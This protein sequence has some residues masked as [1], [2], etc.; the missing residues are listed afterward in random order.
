MRSHLRPLLIV[1]FLAEPQSLVRA[2]AMST[3]S[4]RGE[5]FEPGFTPSCNLMSATGNAVDT[6]V[7]EIS[8][9]CCE[10]TDSD[11]DDSCTRWC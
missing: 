11:D 4:C 3:I 2:V 7:I 5:G 6:V 8:S 10:S 1:V 9:S